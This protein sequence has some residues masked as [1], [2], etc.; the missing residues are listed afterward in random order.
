MGFM[1]NINWNKAGNF[2]KAGVQEMMLARPEQAAGQVIYKHPDRTVPKFAQLT[3]RADEACC[4][5]RDG[6]SSGRFAPD[7]TPWIP[8]TSRS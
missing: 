8:R 1:D 4:F 7:G 3:V 5:F 2:I 6:E